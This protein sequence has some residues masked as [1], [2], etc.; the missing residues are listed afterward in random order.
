[1]LTGVLALTSISALFA[2][3]AATD[4]EAAAAELAKKLSD[5]VAA[6]TSVPISSRSSPSR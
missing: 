4:S 6:L 5:P 2:Q 3:D 1:M